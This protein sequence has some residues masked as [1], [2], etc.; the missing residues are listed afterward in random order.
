MKITPVY[1]PQKNPAFLWDEAAKN[2]SPPLLTC[3]LWGQKSHLPPS[4]GVHL[5]SEP[6]L[7]P[8]EGETTWRPGGGHFC[9]TG[10]GDA[11]QW[12][13]IGIILIKHPRLIPNP[14]LS[15]ELFLLLSTFHQ[16]SPQEV[17]ANAPFYR[18]GNGGSDRCLHLLKVTS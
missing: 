3:L 5:C 2:Q 9:R 10:Y 4:S 17:E 13:V 18:R 15:P 6:S 14:T 8:H 12:T 7:I 16:A 1:S 11:E